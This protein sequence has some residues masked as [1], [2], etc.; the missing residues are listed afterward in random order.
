MQEVLGLRVAKECK[1]CREE[2]EDGG[3]MAQKWLCNRCKP[4]KKDTN[5]HGEMWKPTLKLEEGK[6][7]VEKK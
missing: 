5:E 3:F 1:I 2:F 4:Q 7:P 6:V